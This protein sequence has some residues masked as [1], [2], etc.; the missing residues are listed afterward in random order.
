MGDNLCKRYLK[1]NAHQHYRNFVCV[2][3]ELNNKVKFLKYFFRFLK[4]NH[5]ALNVLHYIEVFPSID[6]N[7]MAQSAVKYLST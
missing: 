4:F 3:A 5:I 1:G 7:A 2:D 6:C